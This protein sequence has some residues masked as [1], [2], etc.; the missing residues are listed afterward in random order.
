MRCRR[1]HHA[2]WVSCLLSF[3]VSSAL[4]TRRRHPYR[5]PPRDVL[6]NIQITSSD[7]YADGGNGHVMEERIIGGDYPSEEEYRQHSSYVVAL[8]QVRTCGCQTHAATAFGCLSRVGS[9]F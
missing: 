1:L 2:L 8:V 3:L 4:A 5:H 7:D 6:Q 9:S